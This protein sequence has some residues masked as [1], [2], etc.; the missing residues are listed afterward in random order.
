MCVYRAIACH[1]HNND[2]I[3]IIVIVP[4]LF[5]FSRFIFII[6][7]TSLHHTYHTVRDRDDR[8]R[9]RV[10][11]ESSRK[12]KTKNTAAGRT[13]SVH[14]TQQAH[15]PDPHYALQQHTHTTHTNTRHGHDAYEYVN[16]Y[17]TPSTGRRST[18]GAR[19]LQGH[20][21]KGQGA[22]RAKHIQHKIPSSRALYP[23]YQH[24]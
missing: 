16:T 13:Q 7:I 22:A 23:L 21:S 5:S 4:F 17:H 11:S 15:T 18:N 6:I 1:H 20:T 8:L 9:V 14:S 24:T 12:H 2:V 3:I 10:S 19:R